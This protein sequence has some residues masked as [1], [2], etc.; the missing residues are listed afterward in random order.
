MNVRAQVVRKLAVLGF[1]AVSVVGIGMASPAAA[2]D[3]GD[4]SPDQVVLTGGLHVAEGETVGTA[5]VFNGPVL[6]EGTVTETLVVFNGRTEIS[7]SVQED[8]LVFRGAVLVRSGA[9]IGGDVASTDDATVQEGAA[10]SGKVESITSHLDVGRIGLA[11]RI[12]WWIAYTV[13]ALILGLLLLLF[14]PR[15]DEAIAI[16]AGT[17]KGA[18]FGLGVA[19]FFLIP[20]VA[21][22]LLVTIVGAPLGLFILLALALIYTVGYVVGAHAIGRLIVKA[23]TSRFLAFLAGLAILRLIELVPVVGGLVWLL[24]TIFGLGVLILAARRRNTVVVT[25]DAPPAPVLTAG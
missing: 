17:R 14:A 11:S 1:L 2:D 3:D 21:V 15:I 18:A 13:S 25:P 6:I 7:G 20:I 12:A 5:V 8:V 4:D 24:A 19:A 9:E 10:V 22:L 23:P 16:T